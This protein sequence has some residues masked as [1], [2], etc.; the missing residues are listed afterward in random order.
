MHYM[1]PEI[2]LTIVSTP[3]IDFASL[4][5][6]TRVN[7]EWISL[8]YDSNTLRAKLFL[9]PRI[10]SGGLVNVDDARYTAPTSVRIILDVRLEDRK[11]SHEAM[12][13]AP[14]GDVALHPLLLRER[15]GVNFG[16][17]I[18][19]TLSCRILRILHNLRKERRCSWQDMCNTQSLVELHRSTCA[20]T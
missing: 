7:K 19:F 17:S 10:T 13:H 18:A 11:P 6:C 1:P 12:S 3:G 4:L 9:S 5:R 16:D 20:S 15:F 8:I 2:I 14:L